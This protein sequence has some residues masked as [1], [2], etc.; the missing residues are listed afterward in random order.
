LITKKKQKL[1]FKTGWITSSDYIKRNDQINPMKRINYK[2]A[3]KECDAKSKIFCLI[4]TEYDCFVKKL[5]EIPSGN[6]VN[7]M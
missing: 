3:I 2:R 4:E 6:N 7:H 1:E 5:N